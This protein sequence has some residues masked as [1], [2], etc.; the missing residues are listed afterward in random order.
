MGME[1]AFDRPRSV[2]RAPESTRD[3]REGSAA[4]QAEQIA[5]GQ[6]RIP[7]GERAFE[8][9]PTS[10][11][12]APAQSADPMPLIAALAKI[13]VL[14]AIGLLVWWRFFYSPVPTSEEIE[15]AFVPVA[16]YEY[17]SSESP[18]AKAV[19]GF[20]TGYLSEEDVG[21]FQARELYS[22]D[23]AIGVAMI[24]GVDYDDVRDDFAPGAIQEGAKEITLGTPGKMFTAFEGVHS[25]AYVIVW[26]DEDGYVYA[27]ATN[28]PTHSRNVATALGTAAL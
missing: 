10:S 17:G 26:A 27:V 14:L 11:S 7:V 22:G 3:P 24:G 4:W 20:M 2:P 8:P 12:G 18:V 16:G 15:A 9:L 13:G 5:T 28:Y 6:M 25:G 19:D 1:G 23:R 21:D